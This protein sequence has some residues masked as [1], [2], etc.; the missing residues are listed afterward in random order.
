[1]T[2]TLI[3]GGGTAGCVLAARLSEHPDHT[4]RLLEA[5]PVWRAPAEVPARL[6][7]ATR[8][9]LE[10]D[11]L[12]LWRYPVSLAAADGAEQTGSIVRGRAIGGSSAVNG[13]YFV[14]AAPADFAAWRQVLNGANTW[15]FDAVLPAYRRSEHDLD[16]GDR[17]WHGR[18]G[19]IP[20]RRTADPVPL[21]EEFANAC[22][23]AGFPL[24]SDLN[25][26]AD[27]TDG[28]GRV[29]CNIADGV[30]TSTAL[31]YL[32]PALTRPNLTVHGDTSALR[33]VFRGTRAVGVEVLRAGRT[34]TVWADRIVLSAGAIE[35]AALLLRSGVGDPEQLRAA[36]IPVVHPAPVGAWCTD[37]PEIGL[38]Y[39]VPA[40]ARAAVAL[41]YALA[42]DDLEFRPYTVAFTPGTYRL[43]VALMRPES[44][45]TVR[46]RAADPATPPDVRLGHLRAERDR[47]RLRTA[48]D[49]AMELLHRMSAQPRTDPMP[50][51][52][53]QADAWLRANLA[54]SQHLSGTCRMGPPHDERA[55]VDERCRVH[56]VTALSIVDLSVVPV[57]LGR[58]PQ[59]TV[60][61]IA[62]HAAAH[63]TT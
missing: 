2:D 61:M 8:L 51:P 57:P 37:H 53:A 33:I 20:V 25:A 49:T 22:V 47:A 41:E 43:G 17:R 21:S 62:E 29:P 59:A 4:V 1:M 10:A 31:A 24:L 19:P 26:P 32:L 48:V 58:G 45:G 6:R 56:G 12:W 18:A 36:G 7:D 30:R 46:L 13:S 38:E 28:V 60:V 63:L 3:V 35:T 54:T 5:G 55:V 39:R 50:R 52:P 16:F 23:V 27:A 34:E 14:R 40:P 9:P 44:A 11:A 15:S 42:L